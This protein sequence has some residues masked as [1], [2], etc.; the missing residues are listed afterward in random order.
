[1]VYITVMENYNNFDNGFLFFAHVSP[2]CDHK[3]EFCKLKRFLIGE[4]S[5]SFRHQ[6]QVFLI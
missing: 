1:M 3:T 5:V 2:V 6:P 4:K